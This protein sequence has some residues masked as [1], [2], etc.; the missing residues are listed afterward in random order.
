[1]K[2]LRLPFSRRST[3]LSAFGPVNR[4]GSYL[5]PELN[6]NGS[7]LFSKR[8]IALAAA[9]AAG[10]CVDQHKE[11]AKYRKVLDGSAPLA[12]ERDYSNGRQLTLE[13]ALLLANGYNEQLD[14]QG[15]TY[16]Q[17]LIARDRA[18]A[19][20]APTIS[21]APTFTWENRPVNR[22]STILVGGTGAG[23]GTGTVVTGGRN[24]SSIVLT[25][26]GISRST[27]P[28]FPCWRNM[29]TRKRASPAIA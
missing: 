10:G 6:R 15:E 1:M 12:I 14:I 23:T 24:N 13:Q 2:P 3:R 19:A 27:A 8:W 28:T 7:Y 20:F 26:M 9:L 18:Y 4:D 16:L 29:F 17:G 22:G 11:V 25:R 5:F 21:L